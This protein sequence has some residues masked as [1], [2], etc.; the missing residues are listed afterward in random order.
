MINLPPLFLDEL[1]CR[2]G[3][4]RKSGEA[5]RSGERELQKTTERAGGRGAKKER[6]TGVAEIG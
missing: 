2:S 5:E 3:A 4:S 6:G 1:Y